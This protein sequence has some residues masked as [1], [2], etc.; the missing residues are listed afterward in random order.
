MQRALSLLIALA[1]LVAT[2]CLAACGS[3][4]ALQPPASMPGGYVF[5]NVAVLDPDRAQLSP[6]Q[7]VLVL[8]GF[9]VARGTIADS[10]IT[11]D[12][13]EIDGHGRVLMPGLIDMH[14]HV[15]DESDLAAN[16]AVGVTTVRNMG[17]F[18]FHLPLARRIEAG[19]ILGP[20]L[21][22]TGPILN[23]AGGRNSNLL[24]W[25]VAGADEA[26]DAVRRQY[27]RGFRH[28]KVYSNLSRESFAAIL[29]EAERLGMEVSGHPVEGTPED[30]VDIGMTLAAHLVT[31]EHAESIVWHG[32]H[33]DTDPARGQALAER[34]AAA[35]ATVTP[36]L[37]VHENLTRI[38]ETGGAHLQRSDMASFNPVVAGFEQDSYDFWI[39]TGGAERRVMQS[40]YTRF[41]GQLHAAGVRIVVGTDAGIM[42][43]PP[44]VSVLREMELLV[45]AGLSP[46]EALQA[47][48][49]N[50]ADA[51]GL[52]GAIGCVKTGCRADLVLADRDPR[53]D[54]QLLRHPAGVMRG[55]VWL[56]PARLDALS[57]AAT[58]P[59]EVRS[60]LRLLVHL[61]AM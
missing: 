53:D 42:A 24:Q 20:R 15:F 35:G 25:A 32:L 22:T 27:A 13:L 23:E 10:A 54:F 50:P 26:R 58:R 7:D 52:A 1:C 40:V 3:P 37:V 43:T 59:S 46:A 51:L 45:D 57:D 33:D 29:D 19:D 4:E 48:T 60:W 8:G 44:G 38:G 28:L 55:G 18:P 39:R 61:A 14:V 5:R 16:L 30:P 31:I 11:G 6:P 9:I 56:D 21:L 34:I 2:A 49:T 41:T 12:V 36:T 47:A 17:G